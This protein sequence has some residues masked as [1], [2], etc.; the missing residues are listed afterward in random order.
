MKFTK[1]QK[2]K[3]KQLKKEYAEISNNHNKKY[4]KLCDEFGMKE[5]DDEWLFDYI[6]NGGGSI[7]LIEQNGLVKKKLPELEIP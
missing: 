3:I 2:E 4:V 5:F 6:Y 7:K 1:I